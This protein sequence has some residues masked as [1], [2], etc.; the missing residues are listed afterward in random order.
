MALMTTSP[1]EMLRRANA[2]G[3]VGAHS[4]EYRKASRSEEFHGA[5]TA[6]KN[7]MWDNVRAQHVSHNV[8]RISEKISPR[9]TDRNRTSN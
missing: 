4:A 5:A 9:T 6:H 8:G 2:R 3:M 1:Q 7:T